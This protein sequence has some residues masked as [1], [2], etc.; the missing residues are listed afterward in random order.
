MPKAVK[1]LKIYRNIYDHAM[2][3]CGTDTDAYAFL[4]AIRDCRFEGVDPAAARETIPAETTLAF[5]LLME[6]IIPIANLYKATCDQNPR[7]RKK[8]G[9]PN[10]IEG[11][12]LLE[13]DSVRLIADVVGKDTNVGLYFRALHQIQFE[14]A[15]PDIVESALPTLPRHLFIMSRNA[16]LENKAGYDHLVATNRR[17]AVRKNKSNPTPVSTEPDLITIDT[18]NIDVTYPNSIPSATAPAEVQ[19]SDA[20]PVDDSNPVSASTENAMH[21]ISVSELELTRAN[22]SELEPTPPNNININNKNLSLSTYPQ[23]RAMGESDLHIRFEKLL[24]AYPKQQQPDTAWAVFCRINPDESAF[25]RIMNGLNIARMDDIRFRSDYRYVPL[26][27]NWLKGECWR[28][29]N[30]HLDTDPS[31]QYRPSNTATDYLQRPLLTQADL[32]VRLDRTLQQ[33]ADRYGD[34]SAG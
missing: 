20:D 2:E 19:V 3:L 9:N 29:E 31:G 15:D 34:P 12:L 11:A 22:R 17:N 1:G 30:M 32:D 33:L 24:T 25:E 21:D 8:S 6:R 23:N 27:S 28:R 4:R 13:D 10:A 14:D 18:A 5:D 26:L 7:S 16:V